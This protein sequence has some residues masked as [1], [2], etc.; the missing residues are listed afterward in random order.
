M[1]DMIAYAAAGPSS[2]KGIG[3]DDVLAL[4]LPFNLRVRYICY[5]SGLVDEEDYA[6]AQAAVTRL[7]LLFSGALPSELA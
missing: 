4:E 1:N 6:A 2:R 3:M 5:I 7:S